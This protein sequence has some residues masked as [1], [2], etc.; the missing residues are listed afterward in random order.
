[1]SGGVPLISKPGVDPPVA[2]M[3]DWQSLSPPGDLYR[4]D[5]KGQHRESVEVMQPTAVVEGDVVVEESGGQEQAAASEIGALSEEAQKNRKKNTERRKEKLLAVVLLLLL[6]MARVKRRRQFPVR[7]SASSLMLEPVPNT[8]SFGY[9]FARWLYVHRGLYPFKKGKMARCGWVGGRG[10]S[11]FIING[12]DGFR[13]FRAP[14]FQ[15]RLF[16]NFVGQVLIHRAA[17][18]G[19]IINFKMEIELKR[20]FF[21]ISDD[22]DVQF[23]RACYWILFSMMASEGDYFHDSYDSNEKFNEERA[24][25]VGDAA[26]ASVAAAAAAAALSHDEGNSHPDA[27]AAAA[28][29]SPPPPSTAS[30]SS[31]LSSSAAASAAAASVSES[32]QD[33]C[34]DFLNNVCFRGS[35]CKFY[36]PESETNRIETVKQN[37]K[38]NYCKDYQN[39]RCTRNACRYVHCSRRDMETYERHGRMTEALARAIVSATGQDVVNG[40]PICKENLSGHC[41]RGTR[42]RFWHIIPKCERDARD[43]YDYPPRESRSYGAQSADPPAHSARAPYDHRYDFG[44]KRA[45]Y[46]DPADSAPVAPNS[47]PPPPALSIPGVHSAP[48][49]VY[50]RPLSPNSCAALVDENIS[51]RKRLDSLKL[52]LVELME[53]ND[54]LLAENGRLRAKLTAMVK[55]P[56][57]AGAGLMALNAMQPAPM[58]NNAVSGSAG[59]NLP[60]PPSIGDRWSVRRICVYTQCKT[61]SSQQFEQVP[62]TSISIAL[63][64]FIFKY[65]LIYYYKFISMELETDLAK[66]TFKGRYSLKLGKSL[67]KDGHANDFHTIRYDFKPASMGNTGDSIVEL[68]EQNGVVITFPKLNVEREVC[69]ATIFKGGKRH[70]QKEYL[71]IFDHKNETFTLEQLTY[72]IQVK[73]TRD[74]ISSEVLESIQHMRNRLQG[75]SEQTPPTTPENFQM[76]QLLSNSDEYMSASSDSSVG[77]DDSDVEDEDNADIAESLE[78]AL[79]AQ[80]ND[81]DSESSSPAKSPNVYNSVHAKNNGFNQLQEDLLLSE[82]SDDD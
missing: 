48:T 45:R 22:F 6:V 13:F 57:S 47:A 21:V 43:P 81:S 25:A 76:D 1:M 71:L 74:E 78:A 67:I 29:A 8:S 26:G 33:I 23:F 49:G 66:Y 42:C 36:H 62:G 39:G 15:N 50:A 4:P 70:Y 41:S 32:R 60:P 79:N 55:D 75:I 52:S 58:L 20:M 54:Q 24:N 5:V 46:N 40:R 53:Q 72:D 82:S 11:F 44:A 51:L 28:A 17:F 59:N 12:Q 18:D 80:P 2:T 38:I 68:S 35:R 3:S 77:K 63:N 7:L 73:K 61:A 14:L 34:R 31:S 30:A 19:N 10:G 27:A 37:E 56:S 69:D 16:F 9:R 65:C 64:N